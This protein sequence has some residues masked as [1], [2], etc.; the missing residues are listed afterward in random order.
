MGAEMGQDLTPRQ[1]DRVE[2]RYRRIVTDIPV[3]ESVPI[4][5]RLREFEPR[6]MGGQPPVIWDRAEGFQ[7]YDRW[8]NM[9]LDW[10]SGVLVTN[11]GHSHPKICRAM[12]DQIQHGLTHNYCFPSEI[13]AQFV[14]ELAQVAP[15]GLEKVFLLT[16]GSEACECAIKLARTHGRRIDENKITI[17]SYH[18]AFHGRT[19][20]S[21]MAGGIPALKQWIVN[22]DP[23]IRSQ[24]GL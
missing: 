1:V 7:V 10:S 22:L 21:Q 14:A 23:N 15:V 13:R 17:V 11:A 5:E 18:N 16:T 20:G 12:S 8:G 6:S 3:P 19:L 2:T 4:L 24:Y 9:W